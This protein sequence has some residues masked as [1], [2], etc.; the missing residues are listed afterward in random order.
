MK[1]TIV[2]VLTFL[3]V[4]FLTGS[5]IALGD[6][7]YNVLA[8][9]YLTEGFSAVI[10]FYAQNAIGDSVFMIL[11][12]AF[13]ASGV[14]LY[15]LIR[16]KSRLTPEKRWAAVFG[17]TLTFLVLVTVAVPVN[18][19]ALPNF[20]YPISLITN[21]IMF[22]I[23]L[24]SVVPVSLVCFRLA[25][26]SSNKIAIGFGFVFIGVVLFLV[27]IGL[28]GFKPGGKVSAAVP[29]DGPNVI[30]ITIDALRQDRVSAY[31]NRYV[32]TPHLDAFA[33]RSVRFNEACANNPWTI[34]SMFTMLSSRYPTVHGADLTHVGNDNVVM[35]A[36]VL[37]SHG[38]ETEAYVAN[39]ILYG[40]LG[41]K[42]GFDRY[43]EYGD[44]ERLTLFKRATVYRFVKRVRDTVIPYYT[45]V[46]EEDT[47]EWLTDRL[48]SA[49]EREREKPLFL[50]GHYLDPHV[51]LT[52]PRQYVEGPPEFVDEALRFG[53]LYSTRE[54]ELVPGDS[55]KL[56]P[57]Y[58]AEVGY[59]DE[60]ISEV[61]DL[62]EESG[63]Y[64]NS[65]I[66]VT[67]DHGE[68]FFEHGKYGHGVTHFDE[69]ISI[70]L[71]I[72][73]PG[74]KPGVTDYPASLVDVMPTVLDYIGAEPPPDM[75]GDSL[76]PAI[77][78]VG[79]TD[80]D[81]FIFIDRT[82]SKDDLKSVRLYPYTMIR[83]GLEEYSYDVR[84]NRIHEE[85]EDIVGDMGEDLFEY[86]RKALD[87]WAAETDAEAKSLGG[88]VEIGIN[89]ERHEKLKGLGYLK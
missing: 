54:K 78:G 63:L 57:L 24:A 4:A 48:V 37:K 36:E 60:K 64:E 87:D 74:I 32:R 17:P 34:P 88:A 55:A 67:A 56:V 82:A 5:I 59:V 77:K 15:S 75:S 6:A 18:V 20:M 1:K 9:S 12:G 89:A 83:A 41:F 8:G 62:F 2:N 40:E 61:F 65:I 26:F 33:S 72:Y 11:V 35:L 28:F 47:T 10:N 45:G 68:E 29:I 85:P 73:A 79:E 3:A 42:R 27:V 53:L 13:F 52:P 71:I 51:P 43:I 22:L 58:D 50:W 30:I 19:S 76:V 7:L 49:L 69:V 23:T 21:A 86:Y 16:R 38:Y 39:Q 81:K 70:P 80:V 14:G 31:D 46:P 25:R 84:D 66:I 44:I